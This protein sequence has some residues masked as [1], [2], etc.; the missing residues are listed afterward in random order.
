V[1][2]AADSPLLDAPGCGL[3]GARG[4]GCTATPT[5]L[6]LFTAEREPYG[7]RVAWRYVGIPG[8]VLLQRAD[9]AAGPWDR[10]AADV[11]EGRDASVAL[12]RTALAARDY[13]YRL[14]LDTGAS[15]VALG[16]PLHVVAVTQ[17][18]ALSAP[19]PNPSTVNTPVRIRFGLVR[20]ARIDVSVY[21]VQG[22]RISILAHGTT[23][24]GE[25]EVPW[26]E[27][28]PGLYYVRFQYPGGKQTRSVLRIR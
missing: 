26:S 8:A 25:H 13:W 17:A 27:S 21:D 24:A 22:R 14:V 3:I 6:S 2:L 23:A 4:Q 9:A 5:L 12:D 16:E 28:R 10:I 19:S 11:L 7:V 1:R 18:S 20:E 15:D